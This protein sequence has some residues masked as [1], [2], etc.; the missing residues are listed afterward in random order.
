MVTKNVN[1]YPNSTQVPV[2]TVVKLYQAEYYLTIRVLAH[3]WPGIIFFGLV[4]N[5]LNIVVFLKAGAK[6]NV[7][8][9]LLSLAISDMAFLT[10]ITPTMCGFVIEAFVRPYPWPF[11]FMILVF[12]LYYPAYTAYDLSAFI[13]IS[14]GLMRCA[15]VAMPLKFKSVFTK[16]RT[17]KWLLFLVFLAVLLRLPVLT[18]HRISTKKDPVTNVSISYLAAAN[19]ASMI[20]IK[21]ILNRGLIMYFAFTIMVTCVVVLS[22]KL[23]EASKVRRFSTTCTRNA[24]NSEAS[25]HKSSSQRLSSKDL[26]VVQ[27][28]TLVCIIFIL[29]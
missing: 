8:I 14:L 28:V 3:I 2:P 1:M 13:S 5:T 23:Y 21:D 26:Q 9:L 7:A 20:R 18:I 4:A 19:Y 29:S 25:S 12:L 17:L 6:D 15:C 11:D 16:S 24:Q 27:S 22:Y 10:L